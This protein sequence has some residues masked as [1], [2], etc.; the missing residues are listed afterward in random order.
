[1]KNLIFLTLL[2]ISSS[3]LFTSCAKEEAL[4][5]A[6]STEVIENFTV[7]IPRGM[8]EAEAAEWLEGLSYDEA[9]SLAVESQVGMSRWC[10]GWSSWRTYSSSASCSG[11][12]GNAKARHTLY[13]NRSRIC[14]NS[15][16]CYGQTSY[17]TTYVCRSYC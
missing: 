11:C 16:Y 8:S 13:Q 5:Q 14:C 1:M 2:L 10:G 3:L 4:E 15:Q 17:R 12:S 6:I 9:V 7:E